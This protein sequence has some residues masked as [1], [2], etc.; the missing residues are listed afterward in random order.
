VFAYAGGNCYLASGTSADGLSPDGLVKRAIAKCKYQVEKYRAAIPRP[1]KIIPAIFN[2]WVG[3]DVN[4]ET[5]LPKGALGKLAETILDAGAD[6]LYVY[7]NTDPANRLP[8]AQDRYNEVID[9]IL[10]RGD[11]VNPYD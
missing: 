6:G 8:H 2:C 4:G 7:E 1:Q 10:A 11:F 3:P 5:V 9:V